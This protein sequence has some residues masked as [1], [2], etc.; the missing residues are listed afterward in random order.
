MRRRCHR[1]APAHPCPSRRGQVFDKWLEEMTSFT[2]W[3]SQ[4]GP[5]G[6]SARKDAPVTARNMSP[7]AAIK[8][9]VTSSNFISATEGFDWS[10]VEGA[11]NL[12]PSDRQKL[13]ADLTE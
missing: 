11:S 5:H 7:P 9:F 2:S 1:V 4:Q 12:V 13:V 6:Y 8:D 3:A 10:A